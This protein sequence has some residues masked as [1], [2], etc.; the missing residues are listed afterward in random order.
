MSIWKEN[1][2]EGNCIQ[3]FS[4]PKQQALKLFKNKLKMKQ[5]AFVNAHSVTSAPKHIQKEIENE[6]TTF[7]I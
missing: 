1:K 2:S 7:G 5:N 3:L 6:C 4:E